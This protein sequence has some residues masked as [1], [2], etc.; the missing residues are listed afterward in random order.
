MDNTAKGALCYVAIEPC[1]CVTSA[2]VDT[3]TDQ[4]AR[5]IG[6]LFR[7]GRKVERR[8]TGDGPVAVRQCR[9]ERSP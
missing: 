5:A 7:S 4:A 8:W 1:G 3:G 9:C 2:V 6:E